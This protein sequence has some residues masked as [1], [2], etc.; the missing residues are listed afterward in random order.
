MHR[1]LIRSVRR[2]VRAVAAR[3]QAGA[4]AVELVLLTPLIVALTFLPVQV[5]LWWHGRNLVTVA[6]QEA[7]RTASLADVAPAAAQDH[8]RQAA[9][10]FLGDQ[11]VVDVQQITVHRGPQTSTATVTATALTMVP[12]LRL[13][14]TGSASTGVERFLADP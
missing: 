13:Q 11:R 1:R 5:G 12:G 10:T 8:A 2:R 7:A 9:A 14:V 3:P 6:A 4:T